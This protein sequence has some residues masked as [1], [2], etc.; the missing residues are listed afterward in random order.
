VTLPTEERLGF[1]N[2]PEIYDRVRPSY[3]EPLF[4]DLF[5]YIGV[6]PAQASILEIGAGTGKATR[7]LLTRGARVTAI[8]IGSQLA[9]FLSQNLGREFSNH[10]DVVNS[11]FEDCELPSEG[12]DAVASATAFHWVDPDVR[13]KKSHSL[14]R[15]GGVLAVIA[16]NQIESDVDRGYFDRVQPIYRRYFPGEV[17]PAPL[18]EDLVPPEHEELR[19]SALFEDVT[20]HRY[21]WDQTY[22]SEQY[23]DLLRSYSGS[24]AMEPGPREAMIADLCEVIDTEFGGTMTRPLVITLT[25]GRKA[26]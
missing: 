13:V 4:D 11:S 25:L 10:L 9:S 17:R 2:V 20:L 22:T 26:A 8:E 19:A 3:P 1:D 7:S 18:F 14:L 5:E 12:F 6:A 16:T 15:P 24:Q 21:R 23:A